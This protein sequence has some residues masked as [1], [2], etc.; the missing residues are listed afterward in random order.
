M[1]GA[2]ALV[3]SIA[4]AAKVPVVVADRDMVYNGGLVTLGINYFNVGYETGLM[5]VKILRDGGNPAS[6]PIQFS[7]EFNYFVN[8]RIAD[9]LGITV[10]DEFTDYIFYE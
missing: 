1:A 2:M 4:T 10:P 8:G 9:E 6:M 5:A 3:S 7:T